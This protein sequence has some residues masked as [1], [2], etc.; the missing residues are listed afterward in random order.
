MSKYKLQ[1]YE[2]Q[3]CYGTWEAELPEGEEDYCRYC[4]EWTRP[5]KSDD[6][7]EDD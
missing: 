6:V 7:E 4:G 5:D 3:N 1:T 2:C